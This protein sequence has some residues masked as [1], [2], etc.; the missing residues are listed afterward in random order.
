MSAEFSAFF[1]TKTR[2]EVKTSKK[3]RGEG[4]E[5]EYRKIENSTFLCKP[6]KWKK[7]EI[8]SIFPSSFLPRFCLPDQIFS[9]FRAKKA[10]DRCQ[11]KLQIG[12]S[13]VHKF[14]LPTVFFFSKI[15]LFR[16]GMDDQLN[17]F[18]A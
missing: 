15:D 3:K 13:P 12:V 17:I 7:V 9:N 8:Q 4:D 1:V 6:Q 14:L 11:K 2:K 16:S 5:H 18:T 10:A